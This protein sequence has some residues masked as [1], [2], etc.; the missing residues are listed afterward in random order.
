MVC[1]T[2][3]IRRDLGY[4]EV[5]DESAAMLALAERSGAGGN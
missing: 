5:V 2:G 1:D 3:R 4:E